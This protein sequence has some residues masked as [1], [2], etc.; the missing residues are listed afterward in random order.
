MRLRHLTVPVLALA[1]VAALT[2]CAASD[3]PAGDGVIRIVASTNV[4]GDIARSIVGDAG[5]VTSIIEDSAQDPHEYEADARDA[6]A[7]SRADIVILNG[8]GYDEFM[9]TLL[10]AQGSD[11][12]VIDAVHLS[13]LDPDAELH[14]HGDGEGEEHADDEHADEEGHDD[15][16]HGEFNEHV[17]YHL[18]TMGAVADE[19]AEQLEKLDEGRGPDFRANALAFN[20]GVQD[21]VARQTA[22][23]GEHAGEGVAITEPVPLYL[24]EAAG[25]VNRTPEEFSEAVEEGTD[26]PVLVLEQTV[27]LVED[28]TVAFLAYNEQTVGPQTEQVLAAADTAGLP[29]VSFS[30]LLPDGLDYLAWMGANLDAVEVALG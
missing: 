13:G 30:E 23:A 29:V 16:D 4:Y 21:L 14:D 3:D 6:L 2:G 17:W 24:L 10:D 1:T 22:I 27:D 28:G 7:I 8:G 12:A 15:H 20:Q 26:A 9:N 11:A 18:G 19:L 25:L 5:E